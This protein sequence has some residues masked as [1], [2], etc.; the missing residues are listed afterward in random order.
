LA[1][2]LLVHQPVDGGV[3]RHVA[4]L[5]RG[6][7]GAGHDVILCGPERPAGAPDRCGHVRL[8]MQRSLSPRADLRACRRLNAAIAA[9]MP[10]VVHAHSSKAGAVARLV[11][12]AHPRLPV[13]Y[14]PHGYAF[15]GYFERE[16]ERTVY[17]A[18]ERSLSALGGRILCVCEAEA[19]L[20]RRVARRRQIRVVHNGIA[21]PA[22]RPVIDPAMARLAR[23]GPVIGTLT[24]LRPGKGIETLLDA[25]PR[26]QAVH[27]D[28]QLAIWG[29]GTELETL[30]RRAVRLGIDASV[31]FL[32]PTTDPLS[33]IVG[34]QV[35]AMPS[36]AES[37]PY[38]MLEA[39]SMGRP[40]VSTDVG[41]VGEA[42][43]SGEHGLLVA[44]ADSEA[45]GEA[46]VTLLDDPA[47]AARLGAAARRRVES[48]FTLGRM[49]RATLEVY[50]ELSPRFAHSSTGP[51]SRPVRAQ[52]S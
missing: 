34:T 1:R 36:L 20:A 23:R 14:T 52:A 22:G 39:M 44:P 41:G 40:I 10:D 35:F 33:I 31:H 6:L 29:D 7:D 38:V 9:T 49:V 4:D 50:A 8:P 37:F 42:I 16:A 43:T 30:R 17:R 28:A 19:R 21:R 51:S 47:L 32:G 45:L 27:S 13:V 46:L 48:D 15:A 12:V 3:G 25:L 2:V 11:H 26:V 18:I 24:Q 5:A